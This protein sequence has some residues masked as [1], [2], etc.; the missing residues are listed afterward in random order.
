MSAGPR[1]RFAPSPTG[2]FHVGGAR[3]ALHNWALAHRLGGTFV[4]RIEDT[5]EARNRPEWTQGIIDALAWIGISADDD[6][7]EGPHF[8]SDYAD[9]HVAAA[10]RLFEQGDAYYCDLTAD[11]IQ[12]RAKETGT[13]GYD[14]FSRDRGLGP[15]PGRVLR[16][17]VP[18][19]TTVVHDLVRGDVSF[20]NATIEDFVLLRGNGTPVFLIANVVDDIEMGITHVV[21]AEEHLPNTPKQQMLW[22]ALGY[23]PPQWGHVPVLVNEQRKKLSKR[24][25][26]VALEQYRDEGYLPDAM[27]NYLMTLGWTPPGA[28]GSEIVPWPEI[29]A[30]FRLEDV[31][32]SPAF[33]DLKKLAAFN[34][35][36]IRMMSPA[37]F[38]E[39]ASEELPDDWDRDRFAAIAPYIQERLTTFNEVPAKVDFLFLAM[40]E[41]VE[42]DEPSWDKAFGPDWAL[43]LLD[44]VIA[45]YADVAWSPET[46]KSTFE[47]VADPY[48]IKRNAQAP[49]RVAVTGR[50]VGPPLFES[51]EVLGRDETLRRLSVARER[52]RLESDLGAA[53]R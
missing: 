1:F 19:G 4:L 44:D 21:R 8:Q 28:D 10:H 22:Q 53:P 26:K 40:G 24:R 17:L 50:S 23:E 38:V 37:E 14:G 5:D 31:T 6:H 33:F 27:V 2:S 43:P 18:D 45:A 13:A 11:D 51:L 36:Y 20:D 46:L 15:G 42:I 9:A 39:R 7:F 52:A 35:D 34:G 49:V 25:D 48:Q 12:Q 16:F 29:E 32:H 3:T 47:V 30:A 41:D